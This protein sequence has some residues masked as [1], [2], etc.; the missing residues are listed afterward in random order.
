MTSIKET[1]EELE[2]KVNQMDSPVQKKKFRLPFNKKVGNKARKKGKVTV[3]IIKENGNVTF[4]KYQIQDQ[5]IIHDLIPRLAG[6]GYITYYKKNPLIILPEW[7]VKPYSPAEQ[8]EKSL[9]DGSNTAGYKLLLNEMKLD[10]AGL[11]KKNKMFGSWWLW[12]V[13]LAIAGFVIYVIATGG[14]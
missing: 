12:L 11:V 3:Q 13:G 5:T 4:E 8:Y 9:T 7:S 10:A 6:A 14:L 2:K 1:L